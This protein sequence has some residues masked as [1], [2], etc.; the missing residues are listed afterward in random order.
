MAVPE[1][2]L[3]ADVE[4]RRACGPT[5]RSVSWHESRPRSAYT[6]P[7]WL[8]WRAHPRATAPVNAWECKG[9]AYDVLSHVPYWEG[10]YRP[11]RSNTFQAGL[12]ICSQNTLQSRVTPIRCRRS[13]HIRQSISSFG[14]GPFRYGKP[15]VPRARPS[16]ADGGER[17]VRLRPQT[18]SVSG[19]EDIPE[20]AGGKERRCRGTSNPPTQEG[21][22]AIKSHSQ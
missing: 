15:D 11:S 9:R 20:H 16:V 22:K 3:P 18:Y 12:C 10:R 19:Y 7:V 14:S 6:S 13:D 21:E 2:V 17:P 5:A 1:S 4:G 8:A